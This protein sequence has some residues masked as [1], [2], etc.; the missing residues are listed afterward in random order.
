MILKQII[1]LSIQFIG[2]FVGKRLP[3][4]NYLQACL[5][6]ANIFTRRLLEARRLL[7]ANIFDPAFNR[8]PAFIRGLALIRGK[9][10]S[11][12]YD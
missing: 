12:N 9:T 4:Y 8:G 11:K 1:S 5:L 10:V 2:K 3:T 7:D 6:D